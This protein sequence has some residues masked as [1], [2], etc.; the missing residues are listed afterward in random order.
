[1]DPRRLVWVRS[2]GA[3]DAESGSGSGY[4]V[5]PQLVLTAL[6]VVLADGLWA[7]RV[8][9]RVGHPRFGDLVR[10]AAQVCWPDPRDGTPPPDAPD[11]AL[12]WLGEP[13]PTGPD[14]V[15]WGRPCGTSRIPFKGAGFPAFAAEAGS[16]AQVED[17]HGD[18]SVVSTSLAGWVLD[19]AVWPAARPDGTRPWAGASGSAVFCDGLLVGVAVEDD[20]PMGWRRLHA[21]P[22]H[23]AL[24]L[25]GFARL[26]TRHGHPG[27]T[28]AL[29][30]V[31]GGGGTPPGPNGVA[32][33]VEVGPVPTLAS[34]FQPR[35]ALR[36]LIDTARSDGGAVVLTQVLS[37]G[38]GFGKTQLAAACATDAREQGVDLVVW[39][40][41]TEVQQVITQYAQAAAEIRLPGATGDDPEGDAR[42]LLK[43]LASTDR[44]WLV[45]L[46]DITRPDALNG[47]WPVSRT[48][49]GWVLATTRL[50]DARLT[51]GG[52]TRV[53][54]DVYTADEADAYLRDRLRGDRMGHLLDDRAPALAEA[55]GHL[56]LALGLAAAHMINEELTCTAYLRIFADRRTRLEDALPGT[57]DAEGYGRQITV[58]LL[59]SL[60][61]ARA[62]DTTGLALRALR[63]AALLDPAGHPHALWAS[64]PLLDHLTPYDPEVTPVRAHSVLRLLH[65]YALLTCDTRAEPRAIRIHALTARAVRENTPEADLAGLVAA[66]AEALLHVWPDVDQPHPD[67]AAALRA[68]TEALT[69]HGGDRL[70]DSPGG[71]VMYRAGK[72]LL[73]AGL[74]GAATSYWQQVTD[75]AERLRGDDHV[76]TFSARN[77]LATAHRNA[78]LIGKAVTIGEHV[79][80]AAERA[81]GDDHPATVSARANLSTSYWQAG[82]TREAVT[83]GERVVADQERMLGPDHPD[84]L[85]SLATLAPAYYQA[86]H[87]YDAITIGERILADGGR[88]LGDDH[89]DL[90]TVRANLATCY[91]RAGRTG[92]AIALGEQVVAIRERVLGQDHP[93]TRTARANLA[94]AYW[95]AGRTG[96]ATAIEE[97]V[98]AD[99]KRLLGHDHPDTLRA[100]GN[101]AASYRNGGRVGEAIVIEEQ[102]LSDSRRVLGDDHPDTLTARSNLG[103]SYGQAGRIDETIAIEEQVLSDRRR[104][105]GDDHPHTVTARSNL[106]VSY[107]ETGRVDDAIVIGEQVLE[108]RVRLLGDL[109]PDTLATRVNLA[110]AY[111]KAGRFDEAIEI[112]EQ[113][114]T[115]RRRFLGDDHP[116]TLNAR[117]N[118]AVSYA[119]G[120]RLDEAIEIGEQVATVRERVLGDDHPGTLTTRANLAVCYSLAGRTGEAFRL[121]QKVVA[122]RERVLGGDH[123][124][125]VSARDHLAIVRRYMPDDDAPSD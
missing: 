41:A 40:S 18:L 109:H 54:I 2:C 65:R 37:G 34:A 114:A 36:G 46:D 69:D 115:H 33:P 113:A 112:G 67:L 103:M 120:G 38:G 72:S 8:E 122:D 75:T 100:W 32:W 64:G 111:Q 49:T 99:S 102:V 91:Q 77:C 56:P 26:V 117:S 5:G 1:M 84:T 14:P 119:E 76:D 4:L 11:I 53:D 116:D 27:T 55:L 17:L 105:L 83:L 9:A 10:R 50:N 86:G 96:E 110:S 30:D 108:D 24:G 93:D 7:G 87:T 90:L 71:R 47:W 125:T 43:W 82:R 42:A 15:R 123:P 73:D 62:A 31:L 28:T 6:H 60:D 106:A 88:V 22:V 12:L 124:H 101:L 25:P 89:P 81:L 57:A 59:L 97:Q 21:V 35:A 3:R 44:R 94:T 104:L 61:A 13:V 95:Q 118:L 58:A 52:R 45:V 16:P 51:G 39:V 19:C 48:G 29:E 78:G 20:R 107:W 121:L 79:V 70:W 98:V 66:A 63:L 68:N 85:G 92:E 23:E 74:A 80:A